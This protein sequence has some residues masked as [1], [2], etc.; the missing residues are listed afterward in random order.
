MRHLTLRVAWHDNAWNGTVCANPRENAFC[1]SLDR[2]RLERDDYR[3][4]ELAGRLFA[5]LAAGDMP[6]C[7]AESGAFMNTGGWTRVIQHPYQEIAKAATTHGHL[8]PTPVEVPPYSTFAIP[9]AW[10]MRRAQDEIADRLPDRLPEDQEPPFNSAWVFG[11]RRQEALLRHFFSQVQANRSLVFFY[12]K[13]GQPIS[14]EISRLV[15]GVGRVTK[16]RRAARIR[17]RRK[18]G[19]PSGLGAPGSSLDQ[20]RRGRRLSSPVPRLPRGDRRSG[21]GRPPARL[22]ARDRRH[23]QSQATSVC[24]RISPNTRPLTSRSRR[25][26]D[27]STAV[28]KIRA[29]GIA[30]GPWEAREEWLNQ[31]IARTWIERGALSRCRLRARGTRIASRHGARAGADRDGRPRLRRRPVAGTRSASARRGRAATS[32]VRRRS[33]ISAR[34]RGP[35]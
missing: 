20:G 16:L 18:R 23:P 24:S 26:C 10:M 21:R 34:R 17:E 15:V 13:E 33:R 6:P 9:F 14:D 30:E 22:A 31:Q 3:E 2:I 25:S 27:V 7:R 11:R 12:T 4:T 29:H 8:R 1:L 19:A 35:S 5:D 28:R 32:G